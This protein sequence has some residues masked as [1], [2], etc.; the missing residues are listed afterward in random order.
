[1]VR[2]DVQVP[3]GVVH[4]WQLF[5]FESSSNT[6]GLTH[7]NYVN[8]AGGKFGSA[9]MYLYE[10]LLRLNGNARYFYGRPSAVFIMRLKQFQQFAGGTLASLIAFSFQKICCD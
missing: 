10:I 2:R 4:Y 7:K 8:T 6:H 5:V 3:R 9:T 1:M